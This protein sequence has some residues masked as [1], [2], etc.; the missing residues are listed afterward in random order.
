MKTILGIIEDTD[1]TVIGAVLSDWSFVMLSSDE[2]VLRSSLAVAARTLAAKYGVTLPDN[3][4]IPP[5]D[6]GVDQ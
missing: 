3:P 4:A 6:A 1:G 2:Q 5:A